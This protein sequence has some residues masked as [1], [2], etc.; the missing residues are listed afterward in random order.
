MFMAPTKILPTLLSPLFSFR[1]KFRIGQEWFQHPRAALQDESVADF[2]E[3]HYGR[4]VVERIADPLLSGVYGATANQLSVRATL[5]RFAAMEAKYGSLGRAMLASRRQAEHSPMLSRSIFTS[6]RRGMQQMADVLV[7]R[8]PP[9]CL[10]AGITIRKLTRHSDSW[11]L[12]LQEGTLER[13]DSLIL[14]IPAPAAGTLLEPVDAALASELRQFAYSSSITV[15][16]GYQRDSIKLPPGF[17]FLV[18]RTEG[19]NIL[20]CTFVHNKFPHRAPAHRALLRCFFGGQRAEQLSSSSD[21]QL[22]VLARRELLEILNLT[23][24]PLFA[25]VSRWKE[26]MP[27]YAVGHLERLDRIERRRKELPDLYLAGNAYQGIG[28]P[29]C[30]RSGMEAARHAAGVDKTVTQVTS[31]S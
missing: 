11:L 25:R 28:V 13:F 18:P 16:L 9:E 2:V 19:K 24:T 22:A 8:L 14:A 21:E 5:P 10:R 31:V 4:E 3:R 20:A 17:G 29:D 26:A 30:I 1:T 27:Q 7:A 15:T 12:W 6:L 23:A